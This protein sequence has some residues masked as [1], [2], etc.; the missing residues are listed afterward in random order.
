MPFWKDP[1]RSRRLADVE[2]L[3]RSISAR[4]E[5]LGGEV[6][7]VADVQA[8]ADERLASIRTQ[9]ES[10]LAS[11]QAASE[12]AAADVERLRIEH[13]ALHRVAA[14]LPDFAAVSEEVRS[15]RDGQAA[16]QTHLHGVAGQEPRAA[17]EPLRDQLDVLKAEV[18]RLS[19][20]VLK[21]AQGAPAGRADAEDRRPRL[22][23]PLPLAAQFEQLAAM[24]PRTFAL[25]KD[26]LEYNRESY[27][28]FPVHSCS[29]AGHPSAAM[30]AVFVNQFLRGDVLDIGCGPQPVPLYLQDYPVDRIYGIDPIS[31]ADRHPFHF[32]QGIAEFLPW[33]DAS[34]DVAVAAT[35]L[36]HVLFLDK[37]LREIHRVLA[38]DG[39]FLVWVAFVAGSQPYDPCAADIEPV[40]DYHLFHFTEDFFEG[41]IAPLFAVK[42]KL[43]VNIE[44]DHH[45][46]RLAKRPLPPVAADSAVT[47]AAPSD[48]GTDIDRA[49]QGIAV[50][51]PPHRE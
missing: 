10:R 28:G 50:D 48:S 35:S 20:F 21:V 49:P 47:A 34:F 46:Y 29:V 42:D 44:I 16:L 7:R 40:D 30:F 51:S 32:Y 27:T 23:H 31:T 1:L 22:E 25:W 18:G 14:S 15:L 19:G 41:S 9:V 5:T 39:E 43:R 6:Q 33:S 36:D 11:L 8:R 45:F 24:V 26:L 2:A 37:A 12:R 13:A 3:C 38:D 4:L 17:V